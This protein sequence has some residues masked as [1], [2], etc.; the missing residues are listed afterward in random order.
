MVLLTLYPSFPMDILSDW[1]WKFTISVY[2]MVH[3]PDAIH[4]WFGQLYGTTLRSWWPSY[5][6]TTKQLLEL[7]DLAL[8]NQDNYKVLIWDDSFMNL[9]GRHFN[10][11][12]IA[13]TWVFSLC[14]I[15]L[16]RTES[17]LWFYSGEN[18]FMC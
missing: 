6:T 9:I 4:W 16:Y 18:V 12:S 14:Y 2:K 10:H 7:V 1:F 5:W 13:V 3:D 11:V 17:L 8:W 15:E